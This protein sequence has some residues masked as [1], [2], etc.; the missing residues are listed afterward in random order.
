MHIRSL[1]LLVTLLLVTCGAQPAIS[2]PMP[3]S[4][5]VRASGTPTAA[6]KTAQPRPTPSPTPT[7]SAQALPSATAVPAET[8][9]VAAQ[10]A[11]LLPEFASDLDRAGEWNRYTIRGAIDPQARTLR[12]SQRLEYTNRDSVPLKQI[13]FHL[14]PNLPDLAG[15]LDVSAALVDGRPVSSGTEQRDAL[16]R[17]ELPTPL[18]PGATATVELEFQTRAPLGVSR[19][20][21]GA[22]NKEAGV[23]ALASA[24]PI[25]AIV[26]GGVWDTGPIDTKGDLVNSETALFD[27]RLHAPV[28]WKL[29]TTGVAIDYQAEKGQQSTRFVSGPQRDFMIT[30]VQLSE[31]S[32]EVDGTR[33][34]SFFRQGSA[35]GGRNALNAAVNSVRA[36]NKRYGRYPLRELDVIEVNARTFLGVEYPGLTLIEHGLYTKP[37]DLAITVAHEVGHMWFYST[38]GND[39]QREAWLDEGFASYSQIIY[40]EEVEGPAAAARELNI[41]RERYR[42]NRTAGRD[43]PV[44]QPNNRFARNYTPIVYGKSVLF[45]Q[46][47]RNQLGEAGFDRFL[48][49]YYAT[50]RYDYVSGNDLVAAAERVCG[51]Q[52]DTLYANWILKTVPVDVP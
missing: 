8:F 34:T 35:A 25:V 44:A 13:Y 14:F 37:A 26:R 48:H 21:Y 15:R 28:D 16:L 10:A 40:R 4:N 2:L 12:A 9:E 38:V 32:A 27:V 5:T 3:Y 50:N 46:V 39:V 36:Y 52:L 29:V 33:I 41:F 45:I 42:T 20:A 1:L 7:E 51:C 6:A 47:L 30:A 17:L 31:L 22:F 24:F 19:S 43:A 23:L 18:Q 11:A 49:D